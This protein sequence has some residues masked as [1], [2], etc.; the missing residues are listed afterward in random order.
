MG[1]RAGEV[2]RRVMMSRRSLVMAGA[3][4]PVANDPSPATYGRTLD[5]S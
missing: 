4:Q 2:A 1:A 5:R 3:V